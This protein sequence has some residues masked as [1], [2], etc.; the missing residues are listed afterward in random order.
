M[1]SAASVAPVTVSAPPTVT[2]PRFTSRPSS[3]ASRPVR[4]E[5]SPTNA[6]AVTTPRLVMFLL[7]SSTTALP[8]VALPGVEPSR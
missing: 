2:S 1:I 6:E 8:A 7:S 5:P 4:P 3:P